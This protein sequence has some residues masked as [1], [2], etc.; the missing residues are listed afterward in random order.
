M[1]IKL[2]KKISCVLNWKE[3]NGQLTIQVVYFSIY[4][5][6][7]SDLTYKSIYLK[8]LDLPP[9]SLSLGF[10]NLSQHFPSLSQHMSVELGENC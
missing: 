10:I 7:H 4:S 5:M 3:K 2:I 8:T 6:V 1:Y 9:C